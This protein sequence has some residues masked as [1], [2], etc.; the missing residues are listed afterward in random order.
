M[1]HPVYGYFPSEEKGPISRGSGDASSESVSDEEDLP[2]AGLGSVWLSRTVVTGLGLCDYC[3]WGDRASHRDIC[4]H[5][6][7]RE[8][9]M[10]VSARCGVWSPGQEENGRTVCSPTT[11]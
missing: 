10:A 3:F 5:L 9:Q 7:S 2:H 4:A 1:R 11:V 8:V 6:N